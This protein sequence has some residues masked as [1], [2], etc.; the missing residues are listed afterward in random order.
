MLENA[1]AWPA[2]VDPL[3]TIVLFDGVCHLCSGLVQFVVRRDT[4]GGV[5]LAAL[6]SP[7]GQALLAWCGLPLDDF[8]TMVLLEQGHA[9]FK[10]SA[11]L[12][13]MRHLAWPWPL[14]SLA[15]VVPPF[16]RDWLYDR[17]ARNRYRLFGRD[18]TCMM[19][20]P[21]LGRRFLT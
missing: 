19:P 20:T 5:R 2:A 1:K 18:E 4:A 17:I 15:L 21:E 14:L 6:Q 13:L 7:K 12:R 10:S 3:D 8:D 16:L 9:Y 11:M